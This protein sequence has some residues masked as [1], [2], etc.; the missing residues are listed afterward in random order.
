MLQIKSTIKFKRFEGV[1][2]K[3]QNSFSKNLNPQFASSIVMFIA[4]S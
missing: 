3:S 2:I 1:I 4:A